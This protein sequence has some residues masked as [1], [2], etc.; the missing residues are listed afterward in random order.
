MFTIMISEDERI[1]REALR[2]LIQENFVDAQLL[3]D[4]VNGS[5]TLSQVAHHPPDILILDINMPGINGIQVVKQLRQ[6]GYKGKIMIH[7]AYDSFS[8]AQDALNYGADAFLLKPVKHAQFISIIRAFVTQ[9]R[10]RNQD[11][12]RHIAR[13]LCDYLIPEYLLDKGEISDRRKNVWEYL[14]QSIASAAFLLLCVSSEARMMLH[15]KHGTDSPILE[16]VEESIRRALPEDFKLLRFPGLVSGWMIFHFSSTPVQ[17]RVLRLRTTHMMGLLLLLVLD[18]QGILL[19]SAMVISAD[20]LKGC[21]NAVESLQTE[22]SSKTIEQLLM[23]QD[24]IR[25]ALLS[26][27]EAVLFLEQYTHEQFCRQWLEG[28]MKGLQDSAHLFALGAAL[29]LSVYLVLGKDHEKIGAMNWSSAIARYYPKTLKKKDIYQW[30]EYSV[31]EVLQEYYKRKQKSSELVLK[32]ACAYIRRDYYHDLSLQEVAD[33]VGVSTSYLSHQFREKIGIGFVDYL[34]SVRMQE[35]MHLLKQ[36]DY[37]IRELSKL[38]GYNSHTYFCR[39][40]RQR[41][42]KTINQLKRQLVREKQ[43]P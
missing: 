35:L 9:L 7:T 18:Q 31:Q 43:E 1:D 22:L 11:M 2:K 27:E 8:Y 21:R 41:T 40:V 30:V 37:S 6:N 20:G 42:G 12:G 38:L 36:K 34:Q 23:A 13:E 15:L 10:Q 19:Q 5:Q 26:I 14:E 25:L 17:A 33:Y 28:Q 29:I 32:R 16:Q 24:E 39:V 4:C 3:D